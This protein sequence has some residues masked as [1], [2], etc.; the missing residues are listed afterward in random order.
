MPVNDL[1]VRERIEHCTP[2]IGPV[3][4][5][6]LRFGLLLHLLGHSRM[7][8]V[9]MD[10][11]ALPAHFDFDRAGTSCGVSLLDLDSRFFDDR[12]LLALGIGCGAMAGFEKIEQTLLVSLRD[13]IGRG[14]F[15][16][17]GA[18]ELTKQGFRGFPEFVSELGD[19]GAGH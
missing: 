17:V 14:R 18:L 12:D 4:K 13:Q 15:E 8:F 7:A 11:S 10:E 1:V 6:H 16:H 2:A 3:A 19:G 5:N 9:T